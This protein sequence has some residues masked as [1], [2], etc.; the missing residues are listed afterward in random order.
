[1]S[2][3]GTTKQVLPESLRKICE[4]ID[5][6]EMTAQQLKD[7]VVA[8][9][10]RQEELMPWADFEHP[11]ADSYGRKLVYDGGDFEIMV[12]SWTPGDFSAMHDHGYT[13]WGAVQVFGPAEH[14]VCAMDIDKYVTLSRVQLTPGRVIAVTHDL[15][16]QMGNPTDE[17]FL[18]LHIY[19]DS[20]RKGDI[21]ADARVFDFPKNKIQRT[22]GG[23]FYSL[24]DEQ[25][26]SSTPAPACDYYTCLFD[27]VKNYQRRL[28][29]EMPVDALMAEMT[30]ADHWGQLES[31]IRE[32][33]DANGH[34]TDSS[35]WRRLFEILPVAAKLQVEH[36]DLR[37]NRQDANWQTYA[38][39]YDHVIGT[40]N[41]YVLGYISHALERF[42]IK[43]QNASLI[44]V[45]CGTG[46]L[47]PR[48]VEQLGMNPELLLAVD[49]SQ[50]MLEVASDR[51]N[52]RLA[53][54][55]DLDSSF[56]EFDV[57][58]CNSYQYLQ[59]ED[60]DEAVRRMASVTKPGGLCVSEFITPD[61]IRWYP[62]VVF[63]ESNQVIS[64]RQ[65]SLHERGGVIYQESEII[66]LSNL[67]GMR[68]S[69]EGV[70]RRFLPSVG[71]I[72]SAFRRHFGDSFVTVDG[73]SFED[74]SDDMETCPS[75]R[76]IVMAQ[77]NP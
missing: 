4:Q 70:H 33:V 50:A 68:I 31:D 32:R 38:A 77:R 14:A 66:N 16:H 54:L 76:F 72:R 20:G 65:P 6:S 2:S 57:A 28:K 71:R 39:L 74:L 40:T 17:H 49:P 42:K 44:D 22:D 36:F 45:G 11:A 9:D 60:F 30:S 62:N 25:I 34:I 52:T 47:E 13:Q 8:A 26:N 53:G 27:I 67:D 48:L 21:T 41:N 51:T 61:H 10:V 7:I 69:Y 59:H 55:L 58:F 73:K 43:R 23:V 15:V 19:G 63:S 75:T 12:M 35:Y 37:H 24:P 5:V 46:W 18:S 1:M 3:T 29:A 64:L 56:G